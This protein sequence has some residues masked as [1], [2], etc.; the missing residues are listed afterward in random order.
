LRFDEEEEEKFFAVSPGARFIA[1]FDKRREEWEK[2]EMRNSTGENFS[3]SF[4]DFVGS[5][6][7]F[8]I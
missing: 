2:S 1:L 5:G 4:T 8:R 3:S 6:N 7:S